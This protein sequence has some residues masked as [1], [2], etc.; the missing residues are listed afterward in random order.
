MNF[1]K[2][3]SIVITSANRLKE[4]NKHETIEEESFESEDFS[5]SSEQSSP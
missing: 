1:E 5:S 3:S 2:N 4:E